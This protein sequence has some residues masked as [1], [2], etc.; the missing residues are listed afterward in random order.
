MKPRNRRTARCERTA[1][2]S[3]R[4]SS[5]GG[6]STNT[7]SDCANSGS[8][9][10]GFPFVASRRYLRSE[11]MTRSVSPARNARLPA[12]CGTRSAVPAAASPTT[13]SA[14]STKTP[15]SS[16]SSVP[17]IA[18]PC[19]PDP[20][21]VRRIS[22]ARA[23]RP[24]PCSV[25][26]AA[27][28]Q[29]SWHAAATGSVGEVA[30]AGEVQRHARPRRPRRST[31]WSRTEPPGCTTA[32]TPAVEQHLQTVGEREERV[33]GGHR[34]AGPVAGALDR[35][36]ARVDPVDLPHPDP[37]PRR[38]RP[39]AGSRSTSPS[40]RPARRR[41][42]R[43]AR[44]PAPGRR[45]RA[46]T[47]P[48]R[49]RGRRARRAAAAAA[50]RRSAAARPRCARTATGSRSTRTFFLRREHLQR[51]V[52]VAGRDHDLGEHVRDLLRHLDADLGVRR[53]HA[54]RTR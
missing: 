52:G 24:L 38:R 39:P 49:H 45:R 30:G 48:G 15:I 44:R 11:Y 50:R 27:F 14:G 33:G 18:M 4:S 43:P 34:A 51:A 29:R 32:R 26:V 1:G 37:R 9:A 22:P 53:D 17:A 47:S 35:E 5:P 10:V 20:T 19:T 36:P 40:G 13:Y 16:W 25:C 41:R 7:A 8:S 2:A 21:T 12:E 28:T 3:A 42:G 46:S 23:T 54:R 6:V 31:S